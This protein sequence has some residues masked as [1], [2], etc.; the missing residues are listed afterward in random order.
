MSQQMGL[1]Q[2]K[3]VVITGASR[4]IGASIA[5]SVAKEGGNVVVIAKSKEPHPKLPGTIYSVA[6]EVE[7]LGGQALPIALDVRDAD[8][9]QGA[10]DQVQQ[11]FG[12]IDVLINNASALYLKNVPD[13]EVKRFDLIQQVN[14]RATFFFAQACLPYLKNS[15]NPHI[16]TMSPPLS[17]KD[18]WFQDMLAYTIS[19]YGMS[20][21]T[22]GMAAEF[23]SFGI[24]VNSLWPKTTIATSAV[25]FNF[26]EPILQASRKDSI[27]ADAAMWII[28]QDAKS[29]SGEFFIDEEVLR[30]AGVS[31]FSQYAYGE[32]QDL[33]L[34][35]YVEPL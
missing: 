33:M 5:R 4:G 13:T 17:M 31:D 27:V 35:L 12:G 9:I 25:K 29:V 30:N 16:L 1:M 28:T 24:A 34:D 14:T 26:P 32:G 23:K 21:C 2:G 11:H 10:M 18:K 20:M 19:K 7:R 6:E 3:T 22:L 8:A 15:E